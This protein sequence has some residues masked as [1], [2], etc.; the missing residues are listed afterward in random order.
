MGNISKENLVKIK[1]LNW[2]KYQKSMKSMKFI[3]IETSIFDDE[4][5]FQLSSSGKLFWIYLLTV[6]GRH[7]TDLI[8]VCYRH[9]A[10]LLRLR[11]SLIHRCAIDLQRLQ[12]LEIV[13]ETKK[14]LRVE[15]SRIEESRIEERD[16][17]LADDNPDGLRTSKKKSSKSK[18]KKGTA[19][20]DAIAYY[21]DLWK[22][23]YGAKTSP[24]IT[25]KESGIIKRMV[26]SMHLERTKDF[27]DAYFAMPD[28]WL[29]KQAHPIALMETKKMEV[30][31]FMQSGQH[32]SSRDSRNIER[33]S[34]NK[35]LFDKF[36]EGD[37]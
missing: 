6:S 34:Q 14:P 24:N 25:G 3:R 17:A 36:E 1:I 19:T 37:K 29:I 8:Q 10:A 26:Q 27:M 2:S 11:T 32:V 21:C 9:S 13:S 35:T 18:K 22:I 15:Y 20:S 30:H 7:G 23:K 5:V 31:R 12:L 28:A 16:T 33:K 4:K